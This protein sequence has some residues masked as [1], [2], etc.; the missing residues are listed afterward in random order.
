MGSAADF[1]LPS[2]N[3][4]NAYHPMPNE[5]T[6]RPNRFSGCTCVKEE[7]VSCWRQ[8]NTQERLTSPAGRTSSAGAPASTRRVRQL[9]TSAKHTVA[10]K[11][12]SRANK[13]VHLSGAEGCVSRWR[14]HYLGAEKEY[15]GP[16]TR[17]A[18]IRTVTSSLDYYSV[19]QASSLNVE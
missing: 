13:R 19:V 12:T 4:S 6:S 7:Y 14:Q 16:S 17:V 10:N 1:R 18:E 9:L 2:M 8:R 15:P 5:F 11:I 3:F